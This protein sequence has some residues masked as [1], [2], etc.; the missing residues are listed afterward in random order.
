MKTRARIDEIKALVNKISNISEDRKKAILYLLER[1]DKAE[2]A[3]MEIRELPDVDA[4][5]RSVIV[6][7]YFRQY[8]EDDDGT[9]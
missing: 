3:L 4:D 7:V 8:K 1:L 5:D 2:A 9:G 6:D